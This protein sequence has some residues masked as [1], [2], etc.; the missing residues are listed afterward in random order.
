MVSR[1]VF[2]AYAA[3]LVAGGSTAAVAASEPS[4][5]ADF[6]N[7]RYPAKSLAL[8]EQGT[9][10]FAVDLDVEA[11]I[12]SCAVTGSSGYSRLDR[13]TCDLIIAHARFPAAKTEDGKKVA[14]TR[15]GQVIWKLPEAYARNAALAPPPQTFTVA[16]L[17]AIKLFCRRTPALNSFIKEKTHCLTHSE[18]ARAR[19]YAE[20][21]AQRMINPINT[22]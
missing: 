15:T 7:D 10:H 22:E 5:K 2:S 21:E 11:R 4:S 1:P 16:E 9:V 18:W 13:A 14:T 6:L 17:E 3:F 8:G 19:S 20:E 12:D